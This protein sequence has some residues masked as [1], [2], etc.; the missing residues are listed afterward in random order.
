MVRLMTQLGVSIEDKNRKHSKDI[1]GLLESLVDVNINKVE[2]LVTT[3][4]LDD[5][6]E[7][8]SF[9]FIGNGNVEEK[10]DKF[11]SIKKHLEQIIKSKY[12]T[13]DG[14]SFV[15]HFNFFS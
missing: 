9:V 7:A 11:L 13:Q 6:V 15:S 8:L 10:K 5:M 12:K 1:L 2:T 3:K 4:T 14:Y